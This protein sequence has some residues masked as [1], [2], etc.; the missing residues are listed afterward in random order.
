LKA[1][2]NTHGG[3]FQWV[4][5]FCIIAIALASVLFLH[6]GSFGARPQPTFDGER[7]YRDVIAQMEL[8]PRITGTVSNLKAAS[9]VAE[10]L[11]EAGWS[12]EFQNFTYR[13]TPC[14]NVIGRANI[15]MGS[16][17]I[18]G[19]HYDTRRWADRDPV[20]NQDPVPGAN[21]GASGVAVLLELAR[22][23]ELGKVHHEIWLV[24]FDA[25]DAGGIEGWDWI[26]G[27]TYMVNSLTV[28]PQAMIVVDM[29]GDSDQQIYFDGNSDRALSERIWTIAW[30]LGYG[31]H[32]I[33]EVRWHMIDDHTPFAQRGVPAVDII[34]F[35]YPYWHTTADTVDKLNPVSLERVGRTLQVFLE[36]TR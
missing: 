32:F 34:D 16:I 26:V 14:R 7:A 18:L 23:L 29:V 6:F 17:I 10:E 27:S 20:H 11:K 35:D 4:L 30:Q 15:G 13:D 2:A 19:A 9:Y 24:F 31:Y 21:D 8:G 25:E 3:R 28:Q 1:T 22:V 33:P 5:A 36:T 12:V